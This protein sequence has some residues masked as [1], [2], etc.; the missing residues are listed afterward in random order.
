MPEHV[1]DPFYALEDVTF[2]VNAGETL[3]IVGLNGSGKT[4][5][6]RIIAGIS[7]PTSG[8][9]TVRGNLASL[10]GLGAGFIPTLSGRKNIYLN[11]AMH[12]VSFEE[13]DRLVDPIIQFSELGDFIDLPTNRY[14]SGMLARLGFSI[15][16]H[17]LPEIALIDEVLAV[18]DAAFQQKCM[19]KIVE[20][21][22]GE[23]TLV[24]VSH[25]NDS[26]RRLCK[27]T[28]WLHHGKLLMDGPTDEIL[29]AYME[30]INEYQ[31]NKDDLL[32]TV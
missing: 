13:I 8:A 11:S 7:R 5:L 2:E 9:L 26:I 1:S 14:S 17:I 16:M 6:L 27:R 19:Q 25:S 21:F 15:S 3:G 30:F 10:I 22:T 18:G 24:L 12:G 31:S 29:P 4:T 28:I 23:R 32:H 20:V